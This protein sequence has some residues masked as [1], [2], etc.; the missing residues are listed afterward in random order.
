MNPSEDSIP[1]EDLIAELQKIPKGN[2]VAFKYCD[3]REG[4]LWLT[5]DL[6]DGP[7]LNSG[8]FYFGLE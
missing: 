1:V 7:G 3:G 4:W 5:P 6:R 8:V 2:R